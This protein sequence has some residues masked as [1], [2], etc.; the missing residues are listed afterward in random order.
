MR[1]SDAL[2]DLLVSVFRSV[3]L[4]EAPEAARRMVAASQ[5]VATCSEGPDGLLLEIDSGLG[6]VSTYEW[7]GRVHSAVLA[8]ADG[9]EALALNL[10]WE[11]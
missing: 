4:D 11:I 9:A 2:A 5:P 6:S 1:L 7:D 3:L 8:A 10:E